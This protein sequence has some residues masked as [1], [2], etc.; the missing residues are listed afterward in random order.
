MSF[1]DVFNA[2]HGYREKYADELVVIK[3][4]GTLAEDPATVKNIAQQV[5]YLTH[6]VNAK[7]ILV[8]GGGVRIDRALKECG[9][10]IKKDPET[11]IRL[12]DHPSIEIID[13]ELR[14]LNRELVEAFTGASPHI[15]VIG[16]AGY[17]GFS[18][19]AKADQNSFTGFAEDTNEAYLTRL[20]HAKGNVPLVYPICF[21]ADEC[22]DP[23]LNV[24]AD[25]VAS[26]L[27]SK[28]KA[29]RLILCSDVPGVLNNK[30]E[31]IKGLSTTQVDQLIADKTV[32]GGMIEKLRSAAQSAEQLKSGGVVILDGRQE[33]AILKELLTSEGCGT[34]IRIPERIA[35]MR[36]PEIA[37]FKPKQN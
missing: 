34:L 2:I 26:L 10:K 9:L 6:Y 28:L 37:G 19:K 24:N 5:G 17:D 7:V 29:R 23:R 3:F 35:D 14:S 13:K 22:H 15:S 1:H 20:L 12:T 16:M 21:N 27:A 18:V 4:G 11:G 32:T 30:K 36:Y 25:A 31:L 8:H 33:N